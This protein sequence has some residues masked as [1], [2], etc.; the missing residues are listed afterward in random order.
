MTFNGTTLVNSTFQYSQTLAILLNEVLGNASVL[1]GGLSIERYKDQNNS[2][3]L[4]LSKW[5]ATSVGM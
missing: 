2:F 5:I 4:I 3:R 1:S